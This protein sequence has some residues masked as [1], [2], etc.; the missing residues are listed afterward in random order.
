MASKHGGF[1]LMAEDD[2]GKACLVFLLALA[3][4]SG[5]TRAHAK[6]TEK[7]YFLLFVFF[8]H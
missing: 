3:V 4:M 1:D 2:P 6:F 7:D 8:W 5:F